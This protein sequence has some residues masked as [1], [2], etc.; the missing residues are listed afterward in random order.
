MRQLEAGGIPPDVDAWIAAHPDLATE[1][2]EYAE[3]LQL[4]HRLTAGMRNANADSTVGGAT[5]LVAPT[6]SQQLGDFEIIREIGRGGMGIVYEARQISLNRRVALKVLPFASMLD[7]RQIA[8]FRNEAL[9][10]AQ[11]HHPHIVPV[12]A[13]GQERGVH[14]IAMQYVAGQSLEQAIAGL[15]AAQGEPHSHPASRPPLG[16]SAASTVSLAARD[17]ETD[18]AGS[19]LSQGPIRTSGHCDTAARLI[20]EAA[21]ALHHAHEC[22]VIHRDVKPSNLLLDSRGKIWVADFGLAR[23]SASSGVTVSGDLLGTLRYMSPE[24]AA[25]RAALVDG[26]ADVYSLGA[27][28]Y[29]LLTL[30]PVHEGDDRQAVLHRI[31][32]CEPAS[33]RA[34]NSA[35]PYDLETIV[36]R[37]L[38]KSRDERY[39]TARDLAD[40]LKRFLS[41]QAPTA[42]RPTLV[43]HAVRWVQRRRKAAALAAAALLTVTL[44]TTTAAV[45]VTREKA[46][47]EHEKQRAEAALAESRQS[48]ARAEEHYRQARDV[49]D[50]FGGGLARE[51]AD[52]PG[53]EPIRRRLLAATL[54]YYREFIDSAEG[55]SSL[56]RDMA[57]AC[58][59]AAG[60]SDTLG[61]RDDAVRLCQESV[62]RFDDLAAGKPTDLPL[63]AERAKVRGALAVLLAGTGDAESARQAHQQTIAAWTT[64]LDAAK[65]NST[66]RVDWT[67][68]LARARSNFGLFQASLGND[69]AARGEFTRA[70]SLLTPLADDPVASPRV[71]RELAVC[72]NNLSYVERDQDILQ[73]ERAVRQAVDMLEPLVIAGDADMP[74][75]ADL[76]LA[77]SNLGA[78]EGQRRQ[79]RDACKAHERAIELQQQLVRQ[80][81]AVVSHR[82]ELAASFSNLGQAYDSAGRPDESLAAFDQAR[83]IIA[84]LAEDFPRDSMFRSLH[85]AVLNNRGMALESMSRMEEAIAAYQDAAAEQRTAVEQTP[86]S[87]EFRERLNKHYINLGRALRK[88]DRPTEAAQAAIL[89]RRL[90]TGDGERLGQAAVELAE[91]TEQLA[92]T[93][94][95]NDKTVLRLRGEVKQALDEARLAGCDVAR[96]PLPKSYLESVKTKPVNVEN[97]ND[98]PK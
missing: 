24:Q 97:M 45:L 12:Y 79:W 33:P 53:S 76:A 43:D 82:R 13:V 5:T 28:L 39:G 57:A 3:S 47:T 88:A 85:G 75:R 31:E 98:E 63:L 50:R 9:A 59:K 16:D 86:E 8:R 19:V 90:W 68:D 44:V 17:M 23:T 80:A 46:S 92:G 48:L 64:L 56:D 61:Q 51:L 74:L 66:E 35:I 69:A 30:R 73:A 58:F 34:T 14:F 84:E 95:K 87:A 27:T 96:L 65:N 37:A 7:D 49:V 83:Q 1:L 78:I 40:D 18:D 36:L 38:A 10:A 60:L 22:G 2:Q 32:H 67:C 41:G 6:G 55:D 89:R 54:E 77:Y 71:R 81:P 15:R 29:E 94:D 62:Q 93:A 42:R 70:I 4:V 91:A 11:L 25:G 21:D 72:F 52:M 26:R 20:M